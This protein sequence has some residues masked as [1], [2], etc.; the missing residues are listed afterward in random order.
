MNLI[1]QALPQLAGPQGDDYNGLVPKRMLYMRPEAAQALLLVEADTDGLIFTDVYRSPAEILQAYNTRPGTQPVGY[2]FH[3]YGGCVDVDVDAT[4]K[5]LGMDYGGLLTIMEARGFH[6]HRR[7][8][9]PE[10]SESWHFNFLGDDAAALLARTT[11]DPSTWAAPAEAMIQQWYGPELRPSD[12][13]VDAM[14]RQAGVSD[15]R[16]FQRKWAIVVDGVAGPVT[17]RVLAFVTA[18]AQITPL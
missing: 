14:L 17:R 3:G 12:Q 16:T 8:G 13:E 11:D 2:S 5:K 10:K 6:C 7:D 4:L 18:S 15:V 1:L 9:D